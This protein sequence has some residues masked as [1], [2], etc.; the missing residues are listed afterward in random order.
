MS[1]THGG[2]P[3][4]LTIGYVLLQVFSTN[5]VLA[6]K[7]SAADYDLNPPQP[8]ASGPDPHLA[9]RPYLGALAA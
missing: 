9:C 1:P 5:F 2:T 6:D 7:E 3:D 8:Y 4:H